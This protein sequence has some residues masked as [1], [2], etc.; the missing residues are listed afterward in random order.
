M[1]LCSQEPEDGW[2]TSV[3]QWIKSWEKKIHVIESIR[4]TIIGSSSGTGPYSFLQRSQ[5][6]RIYKREHLHNKALVVGWE[7]KT[8][9][10]KHWNQRGQVT[11]IPVRASERECSCQKR[12]HGL[13]GLRL[14]LHS[15]INQKVPLGQTEWTGGWSCPAASQ[16][17][18]KVGVGPL[19]NAH[20]NIHWLSQDFCDR[21]IR[22]TVVGRVGL[23]PWGTMV[24]N[25]K[26]LQ[27]GVL[28]L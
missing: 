13:T 4:S 27:P 6:C 3:L 8:R 22:I 19:Q 14:P 16:H 18:D 17:Q 1:Q 11:I 2:H 26:L 5:W 7:L 25:Q 10:S 28:R 15:P 9:W 12:T 23:I 24:F 20:L 21:I